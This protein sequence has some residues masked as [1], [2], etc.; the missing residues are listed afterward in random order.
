M[1]VQMR[2]KYRVDGC[3]INIRPYH[4]VCR[5]MAAIEQII[6]AMNCDKNC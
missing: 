3:G 2:K 6:L 5:A 4:L 1:A